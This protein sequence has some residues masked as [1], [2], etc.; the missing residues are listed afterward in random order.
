MH[1]ESEKSCKQKPK[2]LNLYGK[3]PEKFPNSSCHSHGKKAPQQSADE[4]QWYQLLLVSVS[5]AGSSLKGTI[6]YGQSANGTEHT[7]DQ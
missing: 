7:D 3:V 5:T 6:D 2:N 4:H 1:L